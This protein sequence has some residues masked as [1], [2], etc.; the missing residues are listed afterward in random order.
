LAQQADRI[1]LHLDDTNVDLGALRKQ[2]QDWPMPG[3]KEVIVIL[4]GE[5]LPFWP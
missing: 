5:V 2:F 1:V 3:L 4:R